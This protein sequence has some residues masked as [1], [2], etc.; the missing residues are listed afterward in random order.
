MNIILANATIANGNRGCTALAIS[1]LHILK[2]LLS[3][4]NVDYKI[5]LTDSHQ[6]PNKKYQY[7]IG[8][9]DVSYYTCRYPKSLDWKNELINKSKSLLGKNTAKDIFKNAD[10]VLDIGQG[11]SFA[12]IYGKHRFETIDLIHKLARAYK[13]P[14]CILPQTIGPYSNSTIK[15]AADESIAKAALCMARDRQSYDYVVNNVPSQ[16]TIKEYIDVAFFMPFEKIKQNDAYTHV[17][18]NVSAL[19]WNG[20]Y[21]RDNQFGLC[22]DYQAIIRSIIDRFIAVPNTKVHLIPHVVAE[23]R[24]IENDYEVCYE[25]WREYNNEN[26]AMAPFALGPIE[27]KSYIAGMDFFMGARMHSTIGAFS[28]GVP[29]LPMAYSRKFNGLFVDTL[30]Y[31]HMVDL[32]TQTKEE[33]ITLVEKSFNNRKQLASIIND[34][35]NGIVRER[36]ELLYS[37]LKKFLR[38]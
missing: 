3:E 28:A 35:M 31:P 16:K 9:L 4:A 1:M 33:I 20:G 25:L 7:N 36:E 37:E 10:Y 23:E 27:I 22:D 29:V 14:Y 26:L 15:A 18:L 34:R 32:K 6:K 19:L 17:G 13:K 11:D 24:G 8:G 30:N 38:I 21:T 12:D 2:K 5:Y